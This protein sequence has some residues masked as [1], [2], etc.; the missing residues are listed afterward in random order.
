MLAAF[1]ADQLRFLLEHSVPDVVVYENWARFEEAVPR[2][3]CVIV[4]F[5]QP[6][7]DIS[8]ERLRKLAAARQ[9]PLITVI[10]PEGASIDLIARITCFRCVTIRDADARL[11]RVVG[12]ALAVPPRTQLAERLLGSLAMDS[13]SAAII[14]E[15]LLAEGP[16]AK[17]VQLA[18]RLGRDERELRYEWDRNAR[19]L[20]DCPLYGFIRWG[21][22]LRAV[23]AL[24]RGLPPLEVAVMLE[25]DETTLRRDLRHAGCSLALEGSQRMLD[26]QY[27]VSETL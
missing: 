13:L 24:G 8:E 20:I 12:E 5:R 1:A 2:A 3:G 18:K 21:R 7:G 19:R 11:A 9:P 26:L 17:T 16:V 15:V 10:E 22:N 23:E 14:R 6:G 25:I 4:A 27:V